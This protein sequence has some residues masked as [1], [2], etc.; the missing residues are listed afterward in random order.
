MFDFP[1]QEPSVLT[2]LYCILSYLVI[3]IIG[4]KRFYQ[5]KILRYNRKLP[6]GVL[7]LLYVLIAAHAMNGDFFHLMETVHNYDFTIGAYQAQEVMYPLLAKAVNRNYLL[8][9]L[10]LWGI[11]FLFVMRTYYSVGINS[12]FGICVLL[13]CYS[14]T[15]AYAR[16]AV[17]ATVYFMGFVML[18]R[19]KNLL[20]FR[21]IGL[22]LLLLSFQFHRSL[23]VLI[24]LTPS[25]FLPINKRILYIVLGLMP[26]I[27]IMVRMVFSNSLNQLAFLDDEVLLRKMENYSSG[28]KENIQS[29]RVVIMNTIMYISI[30][31]PFLISSYY[32]LIK[33]FKIKMGKTVIRLYTYTFWL[34]VITTASAYIENDASIFFYRLLFMTIV[35]S[36]A[37]FVYMIQKGFI[38]RKIVYRTFV[39]CVFSQSLFYMYMVYLNNVQ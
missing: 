17:A 12:H 22:L 39:L 30:Y 18:I 6:I 2:A 4:Y 37:L 31:I 11:A 29:V 28:E 5:N 26:F 25:I 38:K 14:I 27:I 19:D 1:F 21:V 35:P 23:L 8:F 33:D 10:I 16:A 20:I 9:R 24:I 32:I 7:F 15:F 36:T 34:F 3:I 13:L